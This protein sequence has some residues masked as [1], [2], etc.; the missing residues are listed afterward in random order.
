MSGHTSCGSAPLYQGANI[1]L[2]GRTHDAWGTVCGKDCAQMILII[3]GGEIGQ[4]PQSFATVDMHAA[5]LSHC[6]V[7]REQPAQTLPQPDIAA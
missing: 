6:N 5:R 4:P 1:Q 3:T 2:D 7:W